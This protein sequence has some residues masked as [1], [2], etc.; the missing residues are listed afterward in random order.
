MPGIHEAGE[1]LQMVIVTEYIHHKL[2][3]TGLPEQA[4]HV[5]STSAELCRY[6]PGEEMANIMAFRW[7][8]ITYFAVP[9]QDRKYARRLGAKW[10][11]LEELWC[12]HAAFLFVDLM[13]SVPPELVSTIFLAG[14]ALG[15]P[16][17][18]PAPLRCSDA[19][20]LWGRLAS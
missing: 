14:L 10:D 8:S 20:S 16:P 12:V 11:Y 5:D 19:H 6:A 2:A 7:Q 15:G 1:K 17:S 3:R 9:Y 4:Q 13:L 18:T